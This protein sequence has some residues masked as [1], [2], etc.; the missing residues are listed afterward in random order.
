[1]RCLVVYDSAYGNTRGVAE[2]IGER[3]R[4]RG[5]D[6]QVLHARDAAKV[7]TDFDMLFV[8]SPTRM[9]TMTRKTRRFLRKL[10][11]GRWGQRL[12]VAFDTEMAEVIRDN[13][14]SAAAKIHDLARSRGMRVHTPVLKVGVKGMRGPLADDAGETVEAYVA[15]VLAA[16]AG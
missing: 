1:M 16:A 5:H 8:G 9:G 6:A 12:V 3:L 7:E 13:G 10:D 11:V 2:L 4:A 14:A 15:E